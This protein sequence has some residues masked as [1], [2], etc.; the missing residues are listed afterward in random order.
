MTEIF[1]VT[2]F[3]RLCLLSVCVEIGVFFDEVRTHTEET[4]NQLTIKRRNLFGCNP[5]ERTR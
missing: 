4:L 3:E 5:E 2:E 1:P